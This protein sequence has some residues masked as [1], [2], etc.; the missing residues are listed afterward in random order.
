[1]HRFDFA[2]MLCMSCKQLKHLDN[3]RTHFYCPQTFLSLRFQCR[4]I[5]E[6]KQMFCMSWEQLTVCEQMTD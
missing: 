1:M 2:G 4:D 3:V 5:G 6:S